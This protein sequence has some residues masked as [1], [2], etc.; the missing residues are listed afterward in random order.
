MEQRMAGAG[1]GM[2]LLDQGLDHGDDLTDVVGG[3]GHHI[4]WQHT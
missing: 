4:R 1:I 3:L 2:A